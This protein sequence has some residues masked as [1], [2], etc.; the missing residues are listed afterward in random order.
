MTNTRDELVKVIRDVQLKH[1]MPLDWCDRQNIADAIMDRFCVTD[2]PDERG[3]DREAIETQ[4]RL[5]R[6]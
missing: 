2:K 5:L 1:F 6:K 4:R 3:E